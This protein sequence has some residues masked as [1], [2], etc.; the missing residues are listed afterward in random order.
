[1]KELSK[2]FEDKLDAMAQNCRI[3][4]SPAVRYFKGALHHKAEEFNVHQSLDLS[5]I[6]DLS[7]SVTS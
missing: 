1:V 5:D 3:H 4:F 6:L 2:S 7:S